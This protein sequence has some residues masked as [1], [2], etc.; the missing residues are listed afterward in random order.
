MWWH[1]ELN[2]RV[3]GNS[4]HRTACGIW[5]W[6]S[7]LQG[8]DMMK[9]MY[10]LRMCQRDWRWGWSGEVNEK[11][12]SITQVKSAG[13]LPSFWHW[14]SG[15]GDSREKVARRLRKK[16]VGGHMASAREKCLPVASRLLGNVKRTNWGSNTLCVAANIQV[17]LGRDMKN[18]CLQ[19][20]QVISISLGW[21]K[22]PAVWFLSQLWELAQQMQ[23][24]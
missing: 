12:I 21:V 23:C 5:Q 2:L 6:G 8:S 14:E 7:P 1:L 16:P 24:I 22:A 13:G 11:L 4:T 15:R 3:D 20:L 9:P 19:G 18:L 17:T 10:N